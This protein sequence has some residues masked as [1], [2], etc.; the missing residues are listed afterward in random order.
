M[1]E[2]EGNF[3]E[4]LFLSR[5]WTGNKMRTSDAQSQFPFGQ[6]SW[7]SL[8]LNVYNW[9]MTKERKRGRETSAENSHR[10]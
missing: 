4:V 3:Q 5:D 2:T 7:S 8:L 10:L 1:G 6:M 9:Q